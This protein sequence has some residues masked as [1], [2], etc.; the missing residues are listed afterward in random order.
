MPASPADWRYRPPPSV[1]WWH[2]HS[3]TLRAVTVAALL[4]FCGLMILALVREQT[5][6]AG[7]FVG[8]ALAVLPVPLLISAFR[9]IDGVEPTPWRNHA[10]AF[11]WGACAA[12]L[13][14]LLAN[15]LATDWLST[16]MVVDSSREADT[17]GATLVAP[18]VE[19]T[20]KAV[21]VLL[22]FRFRRRDFDGVVSGIATAGIT[23][24]GFAFTENVLYLGNAFG[25]D[26]LLGTHALHESATAATFL[27][28]VVLSPFAHPL[29]TAFTGI[30]FGV[31]ASLPGRRP[32]LRLLLPAF[33]LLTAVL[34]HSIWNGASS[35]PGLTF[36]AVYAL[37]M[38][39]VFVLLVWLSVWSRR[40]ELR[41]VR[42][43]LPAY[44]AAGWL[45]PAEPW[46]LSSMRA[47]SVA[48]DLARSSHGP[49]AARTVAEY[50]HFATSL[51][52]L[53][54]RCRYGP[55]APDFA[56]REQE[57][58]HHLWHRRPLAAPPTAAAS[59]TLNPRRATFPQAAGY[60][61]SGPNPLGTPVHF[62]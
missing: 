53:R 34:L 61:G 21:A 36:L 23:A 19:E 47:R 16:T 22:L 37:F 43:T 55:P 26:Q 12:T 9:W 24:T 59:H 51:A 15:S 32:V 17:L 10:F 6:T 38:I 2:R 8:L 33:G 41:T 52:L 31:L 20:A 35:L 62:R 44:V 58:L 50:Q 4:G 14:A 27:I 25:E 28:R 48:R 54:A 30:A 3:R 42:E 56:A 29:F 11:A 45:D 13:V 39:P 57:L 46:S 7:L 1:S 5:G 60:G 18:V 40:N 49:T